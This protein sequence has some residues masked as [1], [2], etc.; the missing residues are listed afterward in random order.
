[1][2]DEHL[3]LAD[4]GSGADAAKADSENEFCGLNDGPS[5]PDEQVKL[6]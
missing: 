2:I 1:M 5:L 4:A 3:D 6:D